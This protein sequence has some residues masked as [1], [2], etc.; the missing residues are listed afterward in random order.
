MRTW[1]DASARGT[2]TTRVARSSSAEGGR[3]SSERPATMW[4]TTARSARSFSS[5]SATTDA[6]PS[7]TTDR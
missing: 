1:A 3:H 7:T 5:S 4:S 6:R 2:R